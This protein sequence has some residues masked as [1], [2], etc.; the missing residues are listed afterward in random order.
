MKVLNGFDFEGIDGFGSLDEKIDLCMGGLA[1]PI[2][3]FEV[4]THM[5]F[6]RH[7]LLSE[8]TLGLFEKCRTLKKDFEG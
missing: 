8:R 4:L 2:E 5:K 6:L 7:I 1:R 3:D